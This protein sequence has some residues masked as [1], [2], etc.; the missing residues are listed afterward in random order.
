MVRAMSGPRQ[1]VV[2]AESRHSVGDAD[3][4]V[5]RLNRKPFNTERWFVEPTGRIVKNAL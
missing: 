5:A 1:L 3:W 4:L 2:Y